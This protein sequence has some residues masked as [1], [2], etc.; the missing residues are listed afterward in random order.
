M[1]NILL[2]RWTLGS[3]FLGSWTRQ[4]SVFLGKPKSGDS[5]YVNAIFAVAIVV[6]SC[7][8]LVADDSETAAF[9]YS[10]QPLL[11]TYCLECHNADDAEG[12]IDL[13][14][15]LQLTDVLET[16][17]TWTRVLDQLQR[18]QMPPEDT[19]QPS[20]MEHQQLADWIDHAIHRDDWKRFHSPGKISAARLTN[21]EYRNSIQDIFGFDLDAG[22][23]LAADPE[24]ATGFANDRENLSLPPSA[25]QDY[26]REARRTVAVWLGFNLPKCEFSIELEDAWRTSADRAT[27]LSIDQQS[28]VLDNDKKP[29]HFQVTIPQSGRFRLGI[30][31]ACSDEPDRIELGMVAADVSAFE[32]RV[33]GALM[34]HSIVRGRDQ[35]TYD[36]DLDL[37]A[38]VHIVTLTLVPSRAPV[39]QPSIETPTVPQAL[40]ARIK[41]ASQARQYVMPEQ[42]ANNPEA[43][44]RFKALNNAVARYHYGTELAKYLIETDNCN[45]RT[46]TLCEFHTSVDPVI[47][48]GRVLG[49]LL[50]ITDQQ[51]DAV[52]KEKTGFDRGEREEVIDKYLSKYYQ[53]HPD[54]LERKPAHIYVN[55]VTFTSHANRRSRDLGSR[56]HQ[57][58]DSIENLL[59]S[60]ESSYTE[61]SYTESSYK[62]II[63]TI[64]QR[65]FRRP[66]QPLELTTFLAIY[67]DTFV[68]TQDTHESLN[69]AL[70]AILISPQFLL[71][72]SSGESD[73]L[74][75]RMASFLWMS[76]PDLDTQEQ[77]LKTQVDCMIADPRFE[78]FCESFTTE[79][80]NIG[81]IEGVND[82]LAEAM[83]RE[84]A[85]F[86]RDLVR[87]DR[88]LLELID[89]DF[90]FINETLANHYDLDAVEGEALRR[91]A[92][93]GKRGGLLTMGAVL[94]AT[95]APERTSP[96][97]RGAW[98]IE[99]LL[100]EKLPEPPPTVPELKVEAGKRTVR[101]ELEL[102]RQHKSCAVCHD[103]ID[104]LGFTLENY[105]RT[106]AW[107]DFEG[108]NEQRIA[109]N[110]RANFPDGTV[111]NG[112]EEF[113]TYLVE[114]RRQEVIRNVTERVFEF[115]VGREAQYYD[116]FTLQTIVDELLE[117]NCSAKLMFQRV[118]ESEAFRVGQL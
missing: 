81:R 113:R 116:E 60:G 63:A 51:W 28:V 5:G 61:S 8:C 54:A 118:V 9:R 42:L 104:P 83:R 71:R 16:R 66:L 13:S 95:S 79:W 74:A 89:A 55:R 52:L 3:D 34:G 19:E 80:L 67:D 39:F 48:H 45:Y 29:F 78:N 4:S 53:R 50:G 41:N 40:E 90:T 107:R 2:G 24:G 59:N 7:R 31:T 15:A 103:R 106:G 17:P 38:G 32:I 35:R 98:I 70:V 43:V 109:V 47:K 114:K 10:I 92:V 68:Q 11:A 94:A 112:V 108:K 14:E 99:T 91:V 27:H 26:L 18:K 87:E 23:S 97:M 6:M 73:S 102:H 20:F 64:G 75:A 65:A 62:G 96:V 115:A 85:L 22:R 76:I 77:N 72:G 21:A 25:M 86:F 57:T 88:S 105:D 101:E 117:N 37:L 46:N 1:K 82:S 36:T 69:D 33:D 100:G 93:S 30:T 49:G 58:S 44:W 110:C 84:P 111:C 12:G 56:S